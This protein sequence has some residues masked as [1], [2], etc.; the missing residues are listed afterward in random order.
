MQ[1]EEKGALGALATRHAA[2]QRRLSQPS[3]MLLLRG[4]SPPQ[5]QSESC[6]LPVSNKP[7][8]E[9]TGEREKHVAVWHRR[10]MRERK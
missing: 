4:W 7:R 3:K 6:Q 5:P 10:D 9:T 1:R 2:G 8:T